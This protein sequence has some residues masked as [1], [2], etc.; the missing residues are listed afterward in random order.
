MS[1]PLSFSKD[2][3]LTYASLAVGAGGAVDKSTAFAQTWSKFSNGT[4]PA[5]VTGW[6]GSARKLSYYP[7]GQGFGNCALDASSL[8]T[9]FSG[10]GQCGSFA[11][12]LRAALGMNGIVTNFISIN[13]LPAFNG[14]QML[15]KEWTP[16]SSGTSPDAAYPYRLNLVVEPA[17]PDG[18]ISIGMVSAP[19]SQI[20]GE[21]KSE[22]TLPG[23]NSAPP[24]EKFF[25]SH[26]IVKLNDAAVVPPFSQPGPYFDPS[27]GAFY[28]S[29][30]SFEDKAIWGYA[31]VIVPTSPLE[32]KA[33]KRSPGS[34]ARISFSPP[35]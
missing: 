4:G 25:N 26:Y 23:Q 6:E 27:Y 21:L 24:S 29:S 34:P 16:I 19:P 18:R 8:L 30:A 11:H 17:G 7:Q 31:A 5:N 10:G 1:P 13:I 2:V 35:D 9:K 32:W 14:N 28:T 22:A 12:L 20:F 15:V 33:F 3:F